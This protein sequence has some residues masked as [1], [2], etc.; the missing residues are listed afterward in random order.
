MFRRR[1]RLEH[2]LGL[3]KLGPI[4]ARALSASQTASPISAE[5]PQNYAVGPT[6]WAAMRATLTHAHETTL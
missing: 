6:L 5:A 3:E 4:V 2:P 1:K